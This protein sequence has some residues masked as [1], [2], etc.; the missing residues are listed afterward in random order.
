MAHLISFQT[1]KFDVSKEP[2]N[3]INPIAGKGVLDWLSGELTRDGWQCTVPDAEDWGWYMM[4]SRN[5]CSYLVGASGEGT[6][7]E[8]PTEWMVQ[9]EK[10]RSLMEKILGKNKMSEED[11]LTKTI[12]S[13][14]GRSGDIQKVEVD[15]SGP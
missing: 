4:V 5:G 13:I 7:D 1:Q 2:R 9:I 14:L 12:Q 10:T 15:K 11:A 6:E 3:P 8:P